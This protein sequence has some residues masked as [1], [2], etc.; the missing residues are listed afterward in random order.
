RGGVGSRAA[1]SALLDFFHFRVDD[2]VVG[3]LGSLLLR[4]GLA[5]IARLFGLL[6]GVDLLAQLL[7]GVHQ[8]F[9]LGLDVGLVLA[10]GGF[11]Q[12]L[13]GVFDGRLLARV[14]LVAVFAQAL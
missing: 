8:G 12:G 11:L 10:L 4:L 5:G 2:V 6:R 1:R 7:A 13:H 9:G 14:E 3:R